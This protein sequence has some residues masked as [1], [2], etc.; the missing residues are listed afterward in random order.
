[1]HHAQRSA[2]AAGVVCSWFVSCGLPCDEAHFLQNR[3]MPLQMSSVNKV[4]ELLA[5]NCCA[6][7]QT[8]SPA[9]NEHPRQYNGISSVNGLR[10]L[11]LTFFKAA[12]SLPSSE[13]GTSFRR[14]WRRY[15]IGLDT[16]LWLPAVACSH[17]W[18]GRAVRG[19]RAGALDCVLANAPCGWR[20]RK[21]WNSFKLNS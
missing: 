19:T 1:M 11:A 16:R 8:F 13:T 20:S 5:V 12:H 7:P 3:S 6:L 17:L 10:S 4:S 14:S 9:A 2:V 18:S 15:A 21:E